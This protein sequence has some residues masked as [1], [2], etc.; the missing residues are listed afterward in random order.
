MRIQ[1][2]PLTHTAIRENELNVT[3]SG[4]VITDESWH[5]K[6]LYAMDSRLYFV[7]DGSGMLISDK[8]RMPL[9][10]GYVYLAPCG[11]KC[12]F[13]GAPSVTK[14]F[15]HI[16]LRLGGSKTDTLS[17]LKKFARLP[18]SVEEI[19]RLT[20]LYFSTD[21]F[22]QIILK[23]ELWKTVAAFVSA[24]KEHFLSIRQYSQ[25]VADAIDYICA[26]L[27]ARL[28]ATEISSAVFCS[29]SKLSALFHKEMGQTLAAY[30]S[31]LLLSDAKNQLSYTQKSI[32]KISESLGFCD[33]FYFSRIFRKR[34][35]ISPSEYRKTGRS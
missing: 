11:I 18:C 24:E 30:V 16:N 28:T 4:H 15:F 25:P 34:F 5:Q 31:E 29:Q 1:S 35:G 23:G 6:P 20:K 17:H 14:L 32:G 7:T 33:Q 26:N 19:E 10:P 22:D 8:D 21:P 27:N 2:Q 9:E 3:M 13:Y 12:G